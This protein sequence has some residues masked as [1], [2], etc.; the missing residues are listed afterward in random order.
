MD[1][2]DYFS[3]QA[4]SASLGK[5]LLRSPAHAKAMLDNPSTPTPSMVF[6]TVV[7]G[8]VL[9]PHRQDIYV[10][11][12]ENWTTKAGKEEREALEATGLPIVNAQDEICALKTRDAVLN[13]P[14]AFELLSRCQAREQEIY[15]NGH[16]GVPHK[17][18]L[19]AVGSNL[20]VDLKTTQSA[21]P[22]D[23][24]R[25]A[26]SYG[27]HIQAANYST[28]FETEYGNT[29]TFYFVAVETAPPYGV[30][31]FTMDAAAID[32]GRRLMRKAAAL[33][34]ACMESG[35]WP[36]YPQ[37]LNTIALPAWA[38]P[39]FADMEF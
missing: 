28:A 14:L 37:Q 15:W 18:K 32:E 30:S 22:D 34:K 2:K 4:L 25:S 26:I 1:D 27:Y 7:H 8:L 29:P 6:G 31:V 10:V 9:E 19:D 38:Q 16:L 13:H 23:F 24:A 33:Y 39:S 17:A 36:G 12:R 11:K 3:V 21:D 35:E 5:A 20:V